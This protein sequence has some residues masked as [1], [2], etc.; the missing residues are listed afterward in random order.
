M[1]VERTSDGLVL[2]KDKIWPSTLMV[3]MELIEQRGPR[4]IVGEGVLEF[5]LDNAEAVY[6]VD[7][8]IDGAGGWWNCSLIEG[9][10][11]SAGVSSTHM[12]TSTPPE[13]SP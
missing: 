12:R 6:R 1:T 13:E 2:L 5:R 11:R 10:V 9:T 7:Q 4:L 3:S 8:I